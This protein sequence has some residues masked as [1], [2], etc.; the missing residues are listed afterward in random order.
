MGKKQVSEGPMA[1]SDEGTRVQGAPCSDCQSSLHTTGFC[2][3]RERTSRITAVKFH[4]ISDNISGTVC[5]LTGPAPHLRTGRLGWN[6]GERSSFRPAGSDRRYGMMARGRG[7][8]CLLRAGA[9]GR[10][11]LSATLGAEKVS[12]RSFSFEAD[13]KERTMLQAFLL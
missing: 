9:H 7:L 11:N 5:L 12:G 6:G 2:R 1:H 3:R 13:S 4:E 8:M 10:R